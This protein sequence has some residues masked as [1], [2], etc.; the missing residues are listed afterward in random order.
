GRR[1]SI[2]L[3]MGSVKAGTVVVLDARTG[4]ILALA[5][6]PAYDPNRP[7]RA[8]SEQRRNRAV[9]DINLE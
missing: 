8:D 1:S 7:G 9:T 4:E 6:T 5:T 2:A 3:A